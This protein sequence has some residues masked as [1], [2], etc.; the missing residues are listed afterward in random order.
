M[1][2]RY[3]TWARLLVGQP[4]RDLTLSSVRGYESRV[5]KVKKEIPV[6]TKENYYLELLNLRTAEEAYAAVKQMASSLSDDEHLIRSCIFDLH[7]AVEIELRRI[8]YHTFK[9]QLFLTD[10]DEQN[11]ETLAQFDKMIGRLSFMGMYRVLQPIL[12]SWPCPDGEL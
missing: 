2:V 7:A 1:A 4:G 6:N 3:R 8:F 11:K 5:S 12:Q 10:D 9:T